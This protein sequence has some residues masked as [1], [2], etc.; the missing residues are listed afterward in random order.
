MNEILILGS[1]NMDLSTSVTTFPKP[2][3][4]VRGLYFQKGHGGKGS[5]QAIAAKRLG[6]KVSFAGCVG[7]DV[8]GKEAVEMFEEEGIFT[9]HL[10]IIHG[11][12]TGT[13]IIMVDES[14]ENQIVVNPGA[15]NHLL[16]TFIE[17]NL[18]FNGIKW[19]LVQLEVPL[20]TVKRVVEMAAI[21]E[22]RVIL[23]PAPIS[24]EI[25]EILPLVDVLTPNETEAETLTG[26][27]V[28]SIEDAKKAASWILN[29]GVKAVAITLGA[30]GVFIAA[31]DFEG[32]IFEHI[33]SIKINPVD[34]TG[35]GD[36]FNGALAVALSEGKSLKEAAIFAV[37]AA[38]KSVQKNG[39]G[40]SMPYREE[41]E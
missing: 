12:T 15:N 21:N 20:K 28:K 6:G 34:T 11:A 30:N 33:P 8:F 4:T 13:A 29:K 1:Y 19:L 3:E 41:I 17:S 26:I 18:N 2:G 25:L 24:N 39:A 27:P 22:V 35:A 14:G 5:N 16:P 23:N 37:K 31:E 9:Q 7:D 38:A 40:D 36:C 32:Y 10:R